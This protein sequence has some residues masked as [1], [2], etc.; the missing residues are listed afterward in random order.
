FIPGE[1]GLVVAPTSVFMK[2]G[3]YT[4]GWTKSD[5]LVIHNKKPVKKPVSKPARRPSP[6]FQ[7]KRYH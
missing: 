5:K 4:R 7:R 2:P 3:T 1:T 6:Q